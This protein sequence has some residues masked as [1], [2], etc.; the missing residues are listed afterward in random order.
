MVASPHPLNIFLFICV[1]V[2]LYLLKL[3]L[4]SALNI[5]AISHFYV[6]YVSS[7]FFPVGHLNFHFV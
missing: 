6:L 1:C 3:I 2:Y 4:K 5:L 7:I